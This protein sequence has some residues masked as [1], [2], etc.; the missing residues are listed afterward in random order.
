MRWD[1]V[2]GIDD[3]ADVGNVVWFAHPVPTYRACSYMKTRE[4]VRIS[5]EKKKKWWPPINS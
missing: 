3:L 2:G 1:R 4:V 5:H